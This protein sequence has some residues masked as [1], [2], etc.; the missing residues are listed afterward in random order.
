MTTSPPPALPVV[1]GLGV[2]G[3]G[4]L[5]ALHAAG[6]PAAGL[7][8]DPG[9]HARR[10]RLLERVMEIG[11]GGLVDTLAR[12]HRDTSR[13]LILFPTGD[14]VVSDIVRHQDALAS[15]CAYHWVPIATLERATDKAAMGTLCHELGIA[16]PRTEW[17]ARAAEVDAAAQA[18]RFPVI[19]KPRSGGDSPFPPGHKNAIV[20]DGAALAELYQRLPDLLG[21]TLCQELIAGPDSA[22]YQVTALVPAAGTAP[23][24]SSVRKIRQYPR[25]RGTTSFGRTEWHE[26]L[27][28]P[29]LRLMEALDW[30]GIASIEFKVD[31][32]GVPWFI[33]LNP[34]LPWY[35]DL[36]T[37]A[38][39]NFPALIAADL[40]GSSD[41]L[42]S[43]RQ[44]EGV[45]WGYLANDWTSQRKA[46]PAP[47]FR[48]WW[49]WW[50]QHAGARATAWRNLGDPV[51]GVAAYGEWLGGLMRQVG[52]R[53][54]RRPGS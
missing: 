28:T 49:R 48:D 12:L 6:T 50:R 27:V 51:P 1:I 3:Y 9:E 10:S 14:D 43:P 47:G 22:I 52:R 29:A 7:A 2:N 38:G 4:M 39:V 45:S 23:V 11:T 16:A 54:T 35:N 20:N 36:F 41:R 30:R 33:E 37:R 53:L 24:V 34:R 8:R 32:A 44:Q 25:Q 17:P 46:E 15:W 5:R 19:V 18:L 40:G 13:P 26:E 42:P 21:R 31:A